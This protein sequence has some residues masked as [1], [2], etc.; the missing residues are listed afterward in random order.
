[1]KTV[2]SLLFILTLSINSHAKKMV[3]PL[4]VVAGMADLIVIG[5]IDEANSKTYKFKISRT[6]KG[7]NDETI[8]V[9][10]FKEWTCDV[11][12]EKAKKG[13]KL[14]LFL[15]KK[16]DGYEIING[17]TGELFIKE[18]KI[19]RKINNR[20]PTVDELATSIISFTSA[21]KLKGEFDYL[22]KST[23]IQLKTA[24]EIDKLS[25]ESDL[26]KWFI[27]KVKGYAIEE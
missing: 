22:E 24:D 23:F 7:E 15:L 21:Y 5:E 1:M 9:K 17:S 6:L 11:R 4:E 18:D 3:L 8:K 10:M 20:N 16:D 26:T 25:A 19:V 13:Q 12:M 2:L 27:D 14:F